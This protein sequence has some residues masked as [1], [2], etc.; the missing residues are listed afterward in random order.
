MK[1][2]LLIDSL[3]IGG[4]ET[5]LFELARG[6]REL[7]AEVCVASS[8]G[9]MS[10]R[11]A[12]EGIRHIKMNFLFREPISA[13]RCYFKL[14][15]LIRRE[16]FDVVHAHSRRAAYIGELVTRGRKIAFLTSVHA[17]FKVSPIKKYMSR[18]GYLVSAVSEDLS[19]YLTAE[20]G[21][22][23]ERIRVI[24]NGVDTARFS[25]KETKEGEKT[26]RICFVSRLDADSSAAAY[27][28]CRIA[29]RLVA[30]HGRIKISIVGGG[31]EYPSITRLATHMNRIVGYE[32]IEPL[33][34]LE[35]VS[36]ELARS[37]VFVGVSRAALE[38][39]SSGLPCVLAGNE[40]FF[41][42]VTP[43]NI[44]LAAKDNF[45]GRSGGAVD[46]D[47]LFSAVSEALSSECDIERI[48]EYI[49][50]HHSAKAS[51]R[52]TLEFYE[53]GLSCLSFGGG[54]TCI[55]G[56][57]GFGNIGDETLLA[58]AIS[59][60]KKE[61]ER[62]ISALTRRPQKDRYSFGVRCVRRKNI[63]SLTREIGHSRRLV[64]GGGTLFQ[65]RTSTRSLLYYVAIAE[66]AKMRGVKVELWGCGLDVVGRM[67]QKLL[68]RVLLYSDHIGLRDRRS[69]DFAERLGLPPERLTLE[70]DLAHLVTETESPRIRELVAN[71]KRPLVLISVSG[72]GSEGDF[73]HIC[74]DIKRRKRAGREVMLLE[75]YPRE[76][77]KKTSVLSDECG[78]EILSGLSGGEIVY[79]CQNIELCI[80]ERLH[81]LIFSKLGGCNFI[82]VGKD[83][84]IIAFC[85]ENGG[86]LF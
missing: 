53:Y 33:G 86:L 29:D 60:C 54:G 77:R 74:E 11:M 15:A 10:E 57:Y 5:H 50:E 64:F 47:K 61:G 38:A 51:A 45:C 70:E 17:R 68:R 39:M 35:D 46:E 85:K 12:A 42:V 1:I 67:G 73:L 82:G 75:M 76:D 71:K 9:V 62:Q 7:G 55:C 3:E 43:E 13:A 28:L 72:G 44:S 18:W 36:E 78:C 16:E 6:L 19:K 14:R 56:Y 20:Y 34:A 2:L 59:R 69:R 83:Q 48:R 79:L 21:V 26:Q 63:F 37:D 52:K 32:C 41:G 81:A 27:Y 8:G 49:I 40:G 22:L 23:P 65:D 4:A 24:A 66:I 25:P 30:R 80:S 58:A 84:K 31:S